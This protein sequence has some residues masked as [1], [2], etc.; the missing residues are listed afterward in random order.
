MTTTAHGRDVRPAGDGRPGGGGQQSGQR[1]M[2]D[3]WLGGKIYN[4]KDSR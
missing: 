4:Q 2:T 3:G 1:R